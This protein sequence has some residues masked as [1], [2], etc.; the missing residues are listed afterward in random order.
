MS[1]SLEEMQQ[2]LGQGTSGNTSNTS[3]D[4]KP[5]AAA[6]GSTTIAEMQKRL[7]PDA[8][9]KTQIV[10]GALKDSAKEIVAK[11]KEALGVLYKSAVKPYLDNYKQASQDY[12]QTVKDD[13]TQADN[14]PSLI[15]AA[16]S[17]MDVLSGPFVLP[18][19]VTQTGIIEPLKA[20]LAKLGSLVANVA[21]EDD[22]R[23]PQ[24]KREG[25][26]IKRPKIDWAV[27]K[28]D[29]AQTVQGINEGLDIL[30]QSIWMAV[31][32]DELGLPKEGFKEP[33][34]DTTENAIRVQRREA[35][36]TPTEGKPHITLAQAQAGIRQHTAALLEPKIEVN[37]SAL[38]RW[39]LLST[40]EKV[41]K[42]AVDAHAKGWD[43]VEAGHEASDPLQTAKATLATLDEK[44]T[45]KLRV[46][47]MTGSGETGANVLD[48]LMDAVKSTPGAELWG[49]VIEGLKSKVADVSVHFSHQLSD[50]LQEELGG[51]IAG[52]YSRQHHFVHI[53]LED[54]RGA[55]FHTVIHELEHA[56]T[57]RFVHDNPKHPLVQ[58]LNAVVQ[59]VKKRALR[60][61]ELHANA[62]LKSAQLMH[63]GLT[64]AKEFLSELSSNVTFNDFLTRSEAYKSDNWKNINVFHHIADLMRR[65]LGIKDK[66]ATPLIHEAMVLRDA[67][68]EKQA[69][70]GPVQAVRHMASDAMM[71]ALEFKQKDI[72]AAEKKLGGWATDVLKVLNP[73][74]IGD[75]SRAAGAIVA[76]AIADRVRSTTAFTRNSATR[77]L[78]WESHKDS[79][80]GFI[81]RFEK[82]DQFLDDPEQ[83]RIAERYRQWNGQIFI[84]DVSN[85]IAYDP[86]DNYLYHSFEDS[87]EVEKW[88]DQKWGRKWGD[89]GFMKERQFSMYQ[90]AIDA[91]FK[92]RFDNPEDLMLARQHASDIAASKVQALEELQRFGLAVKKPKGVVNFKAAFGGQ[93]RR[94]PNGD[95]FMVHNDAAQ[96]MFNAFDS[97]SLW[98]MRNVAG[99]AFRSMMAVK[100]RIIPLR[101]GF[102]LFHALH[103][104]HI[105]NADMLAMTSKGVLSG[106][107]GVVRAGLEFAQAAPLI[108]N[109]WKNARAGAGIVEAWMGKI[110]DEDLSDADRQNLTY[111]SEGGFIPTMDHHWNTGAIAQFK[112]GIAQAKGG[113]VGK[114]GAKALWHAPWAL[115]EGLQAPLFQQWIPN[116]KAA[117]FIKGASEAMRDD[118]TLADNALKRR[119]AF[120]RIS[121]SVD[122]RYGEMNYETLLW[123]KWAKDLAVLN[124]L[125]LG[126]QLGFIREYGGGALDLGQFAVRGDRMQAIREGKL[127]RALFASTY[128]MTALGYGG[129][130]T[131]AMTGSPPDSLTDYI[132]PRTGGKA[133]DGSPARVNT[134]FYTREFAS[135][136]KHVQAKGLREGMT[137]LVESKASGVIGLFSELAKG[138]NSFGQEIRDPA[139]PGYQQIEQSLAYVMSDM[140]PIAFKNAGD[141]PGSTAMSVAG[142][143]PAPAFMTDS[144]T[145]GRIKNSYDKFVQPQ[146]KPYDR[147]VRS[148][149]FQ[150]LKKDFAAGKPI[151]KQLDQMSE[152]E[153]LSGKEQRA[154]IKDLNDQGPP[155]LWM[156]KRLPWEQQKI[157]LDTMEPN[158]RAQYLPH[159]NKQH[160][161][162]HYAA[163]SP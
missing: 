79:V 82:G 30:H 98:A 35:G 161:R 90:E 154:M 19:S 96:I 10:E 15:H 31:G 135:I 116:L 74:A 86:R 66:N 87:D 1:T 141:T 151:G 21:A 81:T 78:W 113:M 49:K 72:A 22:T 64:N 101:L 125:S 42:P 121:Q 54:S 5:A 47:A 62:S 124:T 102:S 63:Y 140:E 92:P 99:D 109:A 80:T 160:L 9:S 84:Q 143:T 89:P 56:G 100:N 127:D 88:A 38:S 142:F 50:E 157:I 147:L 13:K 163:P 93:P 153:N 71:G 60:M 43:E 103:V 28:A 138:V 133:Q 40:G 2:R 132:L 24:Q 3:S 18:M 58:R 68:R 61:N 23:T 144:K 129:L 112:K 114:G 122:N 20:G 152:G 27:H 59:E 77:R 137:E 17:A 159:S 128:T 16:K 8:P 119:M 150:K 107:I 6:S 123:Q 67:I 126:W 118:P 149:D 139:A 14:A 12:L 53:G 131:W 145:V 46:I 94:S 156:F 7:Y 115:M 48:H 134:M 105:A 106:K 36:L 158:E 136:Y 29:V 146:E 148:S 91:G 52:Y 162:M 34:L 108:V 76:K 32:G 65:M 97:K 73:E 44:I 83:A 26:P 111:M 41:R 130:L 45:P 25:E 117:S 57:A 39:N 51:N 33:L 110:K 95:N 69:G 55:V 75:R 11:G 120:R 37:D 85:A 70:I 4:P 155:A 104:T